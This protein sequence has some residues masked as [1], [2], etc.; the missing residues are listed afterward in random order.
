V[1][2]AAM[3]VVER[4]A[5]PAASRCWLTRAIALAFVLLLSGCTAFLG[6]APG[7]CRFHAVDVAAPSQYVHAYGVD[8]FHRGSGLDFLPGA[9]GSSDSAREVQYRFTPLAISEDGRIDA[10]TL[11]SWRSH[12]GRD[13]ASEKW[14][15]LPLLG[16]S[17]HHEA[18]VRLYRPGFRT[19]EVLPGQNVDQIQWE[20]AT[21][22]AAREK[23]IDDLISTERSDKDE[24]TAADLSRNPRLWPRAFRHLEPGSASEEHR[25][26]LRF[27]AF[28][29]QRLAEQEFTEGP[30]PDEVRTRIQAKAAWVQ[31]LAGD[32]RL[33]A[34]AATAT[35]S[36]RSG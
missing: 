5:G 23:A 6:S 1:L 11:A 3:P 22:L 10:K 36:P 15:G 19:I 34:S 12:L 18:L 21:D 25:R 8:V 26:T 9:A 33:P 17:G 4:P 32:G 14:A 27:A 30:Q 24:R 13:E 31:R 29:Y 35:G 20:P 7:L 28:E 2:P 16:G